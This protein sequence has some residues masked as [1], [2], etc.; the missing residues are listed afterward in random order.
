MPDLYDAGLSFHIEA[1]AAAVGSVLGLDPRP[2][3]RCPFGVGSTDPRVLSAL[4][5]ARYRNVPWN[6]A[7]ADWENDCTPALLEDEIITR[8]KAQGDGA[9]VLLHSWP[10]PTA[11]ALPRIINRLRAAGAAFVTVDELLDTTDE[12]LAA[13][14]A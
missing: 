13:D 1:A 9:I 6:V 14:G 5:K 2:W 4:G 7:A 12:A 3:F 10:A 11:E 8:V